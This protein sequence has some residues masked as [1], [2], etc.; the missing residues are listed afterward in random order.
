MLLRMTRIQPHMQRK[1]SGLRT[2][3]SS[4]NE[5]VGKY[6]D[7]MSKRS[8][9]ETADAFF[10]PLGMQRSARCLSCPGRFNMI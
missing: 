4:R 7:V 1:L 3:K 6:G 8:I 9:G 5:C 10:C 2:E